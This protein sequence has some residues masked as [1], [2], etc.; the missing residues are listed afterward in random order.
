[1]KIVGN[2]FKLDCCLSIR[3][4]KVTLFCC[5]KIFL[6]LSPLSTESSSDIPAVDF[7]EG[8]YCTWTKLRSDKVTHFWL[9]KLNTSTPTDYS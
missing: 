9:S 4:K 2:T 5:S 8:H 6:E 1:M 3:E 7:I